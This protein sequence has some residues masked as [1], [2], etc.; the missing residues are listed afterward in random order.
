MSNFERWQTF[1]EIRASQFLKRAKTPNIPLTPA[2]FA[3]MQAFIIT[4]CVVFGRGQ[5][6]QIWLQAERNEVCVYVGNGTA[7]QIK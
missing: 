2:Q 5:R 4:M 1:L 7:I 3:N 6:S